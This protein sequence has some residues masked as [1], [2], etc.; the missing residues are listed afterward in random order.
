[1]D[2]DYFA[3]SPAPLPAPQAPPGNPPAV[4]R[5]AKTDVTFGLFGRIVLTILLLIPLAGFVWLAVHWFIGIGGIVIYG[6]VLVPWALRDLWR[7]PRHR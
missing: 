2:S 7:H 4:G 5:F 1:M 3:A 6:G